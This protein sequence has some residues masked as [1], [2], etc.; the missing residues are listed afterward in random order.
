[1][2]SVTAKKLDTNE[3]GVTWYELNGFDSACDYDFENETFGIT[4]DGR[5]LDCDGCPCTA[6]DWL[7]IAVNRAIN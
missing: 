4:K 2:T 6:G 1:M 7:E 5:V 3:N